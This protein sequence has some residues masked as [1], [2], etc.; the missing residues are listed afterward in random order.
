MTA[1][2][3]ID[4]NSTGLRYAQ[5][6]SYKTVSGDEVWYPLEPN[7]YADFGGGITTIARR[8]INP[9]RQRKKGVVSD[10]EA[11]GGF[12]TDLTQANLQDILQGFFFADLRKKAELSVATVDGTGNDF[13]PASGGAAYVASDL[14]FAKGFT[15]AQN[16]GLH[17]VTGVPSATSVPVTSDLVDGTTQTGIISKVGF[18][19]ATG[20]ATIVVSGDLPVLHTTAKDL[21]QLGIIP[22]EW[23]YLGG[24]SATNSFANAANNGF[25]RVRSVTAT[26]MTFD[27]SDST[28]LAD[29]G[30]GKD[31]RI[32]FGR[33]LKNESNQTLIK[34][35]SYQLERTLGAPDDGSPSAIQSEYVVGAVPNEMTLTIASADKVL[36]DLSFQ[37]ADVEQ[38]SAATGVKA[39]TRPALVEE[40]AFNTSS[41]VSRIKMS[42]VESGV[43]AP[44]PLFAFLMELTLTL[45][46]NIS[47]NNAVGVLG[48]FDVTAGLFEVGGSLTAYFANVSSVQAVRD[49]ADVTLDCH[50][51]KSNKGI[52]FDVPLITL[53][54]GKPNVEQDAAITLPLTSEAASGAKIDQL[55]DH[56]LLMVFWDYLPSAAG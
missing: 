43:E 56:T 4:S 41:D 24:D 35:R 33:V 34:R 55:L 47:R 29:A 16:N 14:L 10:L 12:Q 5:E 11:A 37:G 6:D 13:E 28:M 49:N 7:S 48:A 27:K 53:G 42:K 22:G 32:Y 8:P 3:K 46:N 26:D 38:R 51:V 39:G 36:V 40:D 31:I 30:T 1:V 15:A 18:Q 21:L 52:S 9:S 25:K 20:D 17:V 2:N 19:F 45:S 50:L 23:V 54:D 44:T